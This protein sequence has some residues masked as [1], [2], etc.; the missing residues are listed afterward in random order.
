MRR[1]KTKKVAVLI[2]FLMAIQIVALAQEK[3][4]SKYVS[5]NKNGKLEYHPDEQGN[6][7]P[8][9]SGVGYHQNKK[10]IPSVRN[11]ISLKATGDK[12]QETIQAA[13]DQL[14]NRKPDKNGIRGA[15]L[16]TSGV[17]RIPGTIKISHSGIVLRGEGATTKLIATGKGQRKLIV[18]SGTGNL[19]E[20]PNTRNQIKGS[21]IPV[22]AKKFR[23]EHPETYR[24]GDQVVVFRPGTDRWIADLKMDQIDAIA[25]TVQWKASDYNLAFE[26][27]ITA[28][29]G[30]TISIDNPIVMAMDE[31]YGGGFLYKY[32][33][34]G[35]ISEVGV[36]NLLLE[37]EF[38]SDIDEDHGW[39]AVSFSKV[40]NGWISNVTSRYFGYSCVNL[41]ATSKQITV[42]DSKCLSPKSQI[43][44]GRRYSFNNDG[45]LNLFE[46]CFSLEGRH[47]YVTGA[48]VCGPNVFYHCVSENA[49]ADIGPHHRWT[50][51]TLYDNVVTDGEIN[52]QDRGN[53]GTGHG[54]A[55]ITQVL[56]NCT[57]KRAA[58]QNP[59]VSG[60][61]YV[62]G[63]TGGKYNG[64]LP[65]RS[66]GNWEG[67]NQKGLNPTSLYQKQLEENKT[68]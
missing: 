8:D 59:P 40:Q 42:R 6:I 47:D 60:Q 28:I 36:E 30:E 56:W 31:R 55:G 64:R 37:S 9:F 24:V 49:K 57:A 25:G 68:N 16:L 17:Y 45:Q 63:L 52:V 46:N 34:D 26:R 18:V 38:E 15:I 4:Q 67:M 51:G 44:G 7:I 3:W 33:F 50:V 62:I 22:G 10:Q 65:G 53:W 48:K 32:E 23:V 11:V 54:W 19:H 21:Y 61:N 39:D 27:T 43:I 20:I 29:D 41:S 2:I 1:K 14:A 35:R 5:I 12:D 58:V 66:D 13:I